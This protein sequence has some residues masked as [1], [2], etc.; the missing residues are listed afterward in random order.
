ML[1]SLSLCLALALVP[2]A[3]AGCATHDADA[4]PAAATPK[5]ATTGDD[6]Q[7]SCVALMTKSRD[8]TDVF[9][10]ALVDARAAADQP[11]GIA[12]AVKKDRDGVIA[13]ANAEW[14]TDSTDA[15]IA[16]HCSAMV[17]NLTDE[18]KQDLAPAKDCLAKAACGEFVGCAMP[19]FS[20]HLGK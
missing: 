17:A 5:A 14:A 4:K 6:L 10:P 18:Q 16:D 1:R 8:C 12:D 7:G 9:I 2:A 19:V 11:A 15:H 20:K 13:K 3:A